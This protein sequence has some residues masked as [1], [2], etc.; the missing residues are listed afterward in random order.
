MKRLN[1]I[2]S[3]ARGG[4]KNE[5]VVPQA[6][7][8]KSYSEHI[9]DLIMGMDFDN[10]ALTQKELDRAKVVGLNESVHLYDNNPK[11]I[12]VRNDAEVGNHQAAG[13]LAP[14]HALDRI[15]FSHEMRNGV[16]G[17]HTG[18]LAPISFKKS[19][20]ITSGHLDDHFTIRPGE[21]HQTAKARQISDEHA[22]V[23]RLRRAG[24]I[25]KEGTYLS[26]SIKTE[27]VKHVRH[28]VTGEQYEDGAFKGIAGH[29]VYTD[30][31]GKHHIISTCAGQTRGCGG[32]VDEHGNLD[33]LTG[34]CFAPK[35]EV[36][37]K[38]AYGKRAM[39]TDAQASPHPQIQ[40]DFALA[41]AHSVRQAH[42]QAAK[43]G[44]A[45]L[46]RPNTTD[47]SDYGRVSRL[48]K[49]LNRQNKAI[50]PS[51]KRIQSYQYSKTG[52]LHDPENGIHVTYSNTGPKVKN[53][54]LLEDNVARDEHRIRETITATKGR[55]SEDFKNDSGNLTP[56]KNSYGIISLKK[57]SSE[58]KRFAAAAHTAVYWSSGKPHSELND[59]EKAKPSEE[60]Y[61]ANGNPTTFEK[62]HYGHITKGGMRFEYQK[63][64]I[65]HQENN[66]VDVGGDHPIESDARFLDDHKIDSSK[67]YSTKN[68]KKAGILTLT[69]P[70]KSTPNDVI[71][72]N[73]MTHHVDNHT[74]SD[75]EKSGG[76]WHIDHPDEQLKAMTGKVKFLDK[77]EEQPN[78]ISR[79]QPLKSY[80]KR[81]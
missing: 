47:E 50:D 14:S 9:N 8:S 75:V 54:K 81:G 15:K 24:L 62:S 55:G 25:S 67:R 33:K 61:D 51:S 26:D 30:D 80:D 60:H 34:T 7:T 40:K 37:Y 74:I 59:E 31:E 69:T 66:K 5:S 79:E 57:G 27:T 49:H 2:L 56:P 63:Q 77:K 28:P 52:E 16:Y 12:I 3:V 22:A 78:D 13:L 10:L 48:I 43:A 19:A 17:K 73:D 35:A 6:S 39:F 58:S 29:H 38:Y 41:L 1:H 44:R 76:L 65:L 46:L 23:E 4:I 71:K 32:Q 36:Q 45:L 20:K 21:T 42:T 68:G 70:T 11:R 53:G 72:N 18:N 64:N